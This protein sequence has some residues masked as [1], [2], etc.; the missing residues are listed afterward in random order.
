MRKTCLAK[1][2]NVQDSDVAEQMQGASGVVPECVTVW[3]VN[4]DWHQRVAGQS[5]E[6]ENTRGNQSV[7]GWL[8]ADPRMA[9][10]AKR[11]IV[12]EDTWI[13]RKHFRDTCPK[14][15]ALG[16]RG[17]AEARQISKA[18]NC[19]AVEKTLAHSLCLAETKCGDLV[20]SQAS[21]K[22]ENGPCDT[23]HQS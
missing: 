5:Y 1:V 7:R 22:S 4:I 8:G 21:F 23:S 13:R 16:K 3:A 12:S 18:E 6:K 11:G 17:E 20:P 14:G 15:K 9:L 19:S 10:A 2:A